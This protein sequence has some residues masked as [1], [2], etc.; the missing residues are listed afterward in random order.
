MTVQAGLC[1]TWSKTTLLVFPRG[2]SFVTRC[3]PHS[4]GPGILGT[5]P[6][7]PA[8]SCYRLY[9]VGTHCEWGANSKPK[10]SRFCIPLAWAHIGFLPTATKCILNHI[11]DTQLDSVIPF[12]LKS[13]ISSLWPISVTAHSRSLCPT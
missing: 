11:A 3:N 12:L 2:G 1:Q 4:P 8:N 13:K 9:T 7:Y 5:F 10:T 6:F